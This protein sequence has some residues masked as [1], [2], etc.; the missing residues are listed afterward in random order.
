[1]DCEHFS[2]TFILCVRVELSTGTPAL[3]ASSSRVCQKH[4]RALLCVCCFAFVSGAGPA[5]DENRTATCASPAPRSLRAPQWTAA[6]VPD[7]MF[8]CPQRACGAVHTRAGGTPALLWPLC[9]KHFLRLFCHGWPEP[10]TRVAHGHVRASPHT[11]AAGALLIL[12]SS[13]LARP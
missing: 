8:A 10:G 11:N 3:L 6:L 12:H 7:D 2:C 4:E 5:S 1:M 13:L 9:Q